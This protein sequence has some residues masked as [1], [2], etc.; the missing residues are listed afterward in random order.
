M[1]SLCFS[2]SSI[3]MVPSLSLPLAPSKQDILWLIT[4][5]QLKFF[6]DGLFVGFHNTVFASRL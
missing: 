6:S 1:G 4:L 2:Q 5:L 3:Q